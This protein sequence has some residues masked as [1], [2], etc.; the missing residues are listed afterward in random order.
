M[1][2]K[3]PTGAV[4]STSCGI[5]ATDF[6]GGTTLQIRTRY[7]VPYLKLPGSSDSYFR[8][9]YDSEGKPRWDPDASPA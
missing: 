9:V 5:Q 7:K 8:L 4:V 2:D 6:A 1:F 3:V